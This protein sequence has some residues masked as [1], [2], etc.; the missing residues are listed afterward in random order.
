[1][2]HLNI[3]NGVGRPGDMVDITVSLAAGGV[4]VAATG[5]DIIFDGSALA[6]DLSACHVNPAIKKTL[7]G[8]VVSY[9]DFSFKTVRF[10]VQTDQRTD[11]I[12]DGPLYHCSVQIAPSALPG[13]YGLFNGGASAYDPTGSFFDVSVEIGSIMVSL[14][15][16]PSPTPTATATPT[17]VPGHSGGSGCAIGGG[18]GSNSCYAPILLLLLPAFLVLWRVRSF[19]LSTCASPQPLRHGPRRPC[20][21][22]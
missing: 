21:A 11:P 3:G 15:A 18:G 4:P 5:N 8:S 20:R 14:V 12:P 13:E 9:S 19:G 1:M 6:F 10:F 16:G 17:A 2:V 22:R 7:V